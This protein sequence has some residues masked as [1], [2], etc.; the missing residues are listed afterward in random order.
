MVKEELQ[1]VREELCTKATALD[2]ARREASEV[3]SSMERLTEECNALREN[4]QRQ[5]ALV[6]Q[7]DGVIVELRDKA[8]TLWAFEWLTFQRRAAKVFPGLD[9]NFQVPNE[10]EAE[11]F[12]SEDEADP[13]GVL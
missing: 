1:S 5:E 9:F 4:F 11:E 8:C 3:E 12:I 2:R 6:S 10:E 7:R 13:R